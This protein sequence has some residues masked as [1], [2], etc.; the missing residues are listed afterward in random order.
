MQF[1]DGI[2][3]SS[4]P[5]PPPTTGT[6]TQREDTKEVSPRLHRGQLLQPA[7]PFTSTRPDRVPAGLQFCPQLPCRSGRAPFPQCARACQNMPCACRHPGRKVPGVGPCGQT[8]HPGWGLPAPLGCQHRAGAPILRHWL[9]AWAKPRHVPGSPACQG[10]R[11][12]RDWRGGTGWDDT[13]KVFLSSS[14]GPTDASQEPD[15]SAGLWGSHSRS[16]WMSSSTAPTGREG[17]AAAAPVPLAEARDKHAVGP[18]L[19][20]D[21]I[22]QLSGARQE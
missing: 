10:G 7:F 22:K 12:S 8:Q 14:P 18:E 16:C 3:P 11:T 19:R 4:R 13:A 15:D 20:Q 5:E 2:G 1:P 6:R 21:R 9:R 17:A